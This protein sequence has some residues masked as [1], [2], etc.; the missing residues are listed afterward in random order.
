MPHAILIN[1]VIN[2]RLWEHQMRQNW[3][4]T[5]SQQQGG[6]EGVTA[7]HG[8]RVKLGSYKAHNGQYINANINTA[9]NSGEIHADYSI[10]GAGDK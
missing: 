8:M 9:L 5:M 7:F 4:N 1:C 6:S 3:V 10:G 2:W